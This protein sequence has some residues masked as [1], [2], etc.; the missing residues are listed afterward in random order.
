MGR[1]EAGIAVSGGVGTL[2]MIFTGNPG[3]GK[4]TVARIVAELLS[5]MGLLRKGHLVE[6]D[7]GTLVAG[8]CGQTAL[9]TTGG[10]AGPWWS[11]FCGR[12][13]C[14]CVRRWERCFWT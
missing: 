7:R 10:G 1:R 12:S 6:A 11:P 5:T 13:L 8:F 9:D 3:T 14:S 2:H 4:T